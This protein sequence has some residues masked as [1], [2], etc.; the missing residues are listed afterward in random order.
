MDHH[1]ENVEDKINNMLF[2]V[3]IGYK[4]LNAIGVDVG[5][6]R[7]DFKFFLE[8]EEIDKKGLGINGY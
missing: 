2:A 3:D 7:E 5:I 1:L 6:K 8:Q 4:I